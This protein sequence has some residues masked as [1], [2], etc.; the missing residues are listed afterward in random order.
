MKMKWVERVLIRSAFRVF[1]QRK[2]E[3]PRVLGS[4]DLPKDSVCLEIGC[5][6]GAGALLI[7]Q[8]L[9]CGQVFSIDIDPEMVEKA[10]NY[11]YRVPGW[12]AETKSYNIE[13]QVQDA[14]SMSFPDAFFDACF[15]FG[16][17]DHI[18]EWR[19]VVAEVARVLKPGAF[20]SFEDFLLGNKFENW[21]GHV[22]IGEE[23]LREALEG[24]GF[25]IRSFMRGKLVPNCFVRAKKL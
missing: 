21:L 15:L 12:A 2:Y 9:D 1:I 17:L 16:V 22:S 18:I 8:Y 25:E 3:A 7:N 19:K 14:A 13:F 6:V 23:E 4:L 5:G 24:A 20:F 10:K 11:I